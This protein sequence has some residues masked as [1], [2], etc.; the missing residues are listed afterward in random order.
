M[1]ALYARFP[2]RLVAL[3]AVLAAASAA[4]QV[5]VDDSGAP[6]ADYESFDPA[7][8]AGNENI[9]LLTQT[10]LQELVGP[11]AL[12]P[13]DLLAIVLPASTYPLQLVQAQRFLEDLEEDPSLQPDDSWDD[14]VIAL[15]NYPEVVALLNEDLDW[16][17]RLGE[18]VVAQQADVVGAVEGF[19]DRAYAAGN[20]K[21]D[22]RQTVAR[23]EGTIEITPVED[24]VIYVPY[25][26]P[27]RVVHYQ[28]RPVYHY[29]PRAYPVY[30]YP[31]PVGHAFNSG[32]FWGVTT[33]FTV[34][35]LTD[36]VHVVHH[37]YHGHPYY[38]HRYWDGWWYRRPTIHVHNHYYSTKRYSVS[39]H[40]YSR[41]DHWRPRHDTRRRLHN[42]RIARSDYY[43]GRTVRHRSN[44]TNLS[45]SREGFESTRRS[46]ASTR[47]ND[48]ERRRNVRSGAADNRRQQRQAAVP[49]TS[50][51]AAGQSQR[52]VTRPERRAV[53]RHRSN[54]QPQASRP[55]RTVR[56]EH[57]ASEHRPTE[58]RTSER[59]ATERRAS[60]YRQERR[61]AT[62][63]RKE[64]QRSAQRP[65]K[66]KKSVRKSER[67]RQASSRSDSPRRQ[68]H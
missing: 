44:S 6:L 4:A 36:S 30:Y 29:Y 50:R 3:I 7:S 43:T 13:D 65:A 37:S 51:Q 67:K 39:R 59:R 53:E 27:E 47:N 32:F 61:T 1:K 16:T 60:E 64:P 52:R 31:Y 41:G 15:L 8:P 23:N 25:Y 46:H 62:P 38:R 34:G 40:R 68:R 35:W 17:W 14:S 26:E 22:A 48:V 42:Q 18:A 19:R 57:R 49:T 9:P 63:Q 10:E 56:R 21:S 45:H 28:S 12:Y 24:D 2:I 54:A 11:I 20:L 5:P 66:E 55:E 33:A 58:R